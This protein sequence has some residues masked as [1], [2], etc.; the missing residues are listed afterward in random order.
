MQLNQLDASQRIMA[1]MYTYLP[2]KFASVE[3]IGGIT[4]RDIANSKPDVVIFNQLAT[5]RVVWKKAGSKFKD[6]RF[7]MD[8]SYGDRATD[9]K[10]LITSLLRDDNWTVAY[11][12]DLVIVFK[13]N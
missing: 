2:A 12:D 9:S 7:S 8:L 6:L 11:E 1:D 3:F 4:R 10:E 5:G 13:R